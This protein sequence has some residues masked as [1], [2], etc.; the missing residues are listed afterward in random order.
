MN[1]DILLLTEKRGFK[2]GQNENACLERQAFELKPLSLEGTHA[3]KATNRDL[4]S[5]KTTITYVESLSRLN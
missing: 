3:I 5:S 4:S 1:I 2:Y